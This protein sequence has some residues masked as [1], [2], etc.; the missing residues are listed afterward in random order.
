MLAGRGRTTS[1]S[2]QT[3]AEIGYGVLKVGKFDDKSRYT[4]RIN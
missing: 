4:G 1:D 2:T 3:C